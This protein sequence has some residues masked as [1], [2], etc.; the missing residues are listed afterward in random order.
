[1]DEFDINAE[2]DLALLEGTEDEDQEL[3]QDAADDDEQTDEQE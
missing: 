3:V 2:P 1:M